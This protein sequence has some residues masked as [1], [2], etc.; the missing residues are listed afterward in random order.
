MTFRRSRMRGSAKWHSFWRGKTRRVSN[1]VLV[2]PSTCYTLE[3]LQALDYLLKEKP[4]SRRPDI[5]GT[6]ETWSVTAWEESSRSP[7]QRRHLKDA[8]GEDS[9]RLQRWFTAAAKARGKMIARHDQRWGG[10]ARRTA[11]IAEIP[12]IFPEAKDCRLKS[13]SSV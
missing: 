5:D 4:F 10:T 12:R 2:Q 8:N 7:K 13:H 3:G 11:A 1:N 9:H 6:T